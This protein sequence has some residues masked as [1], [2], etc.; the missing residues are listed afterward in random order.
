MFDNGN[1]VKKLFDLHLKPC[2]FSQYEDT[3]NKKRTTRIYILWD[4]NVKKVIVGWIGKH[5]YLP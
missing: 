5:P 2:T 4:E 1:N 3:D